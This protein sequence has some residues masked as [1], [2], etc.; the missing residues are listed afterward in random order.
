MKFI[1]KFNRQVIGEKKKYRL[2]KKKNIIPIKNARKK[3]CEHMKLVPSL[4]YK[5]AK[6]QISEKRI[7]LEEK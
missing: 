1:E 2:V 3:V 6:G 4:K 5:I 7:F